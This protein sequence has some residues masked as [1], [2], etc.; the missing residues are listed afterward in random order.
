[1]RRAFLLVRQ[2]CNGGAP[3]VDGMTVHEL[4]PYC[5][6][7]WARIREELLSGTY[8]P[9]PV[10]QVEIPKPGGK[11][12]RKLGIPR[13]LDRLIQQS[14]LQVLTPVFDPTSSESS[15][16]FRPGR[17][18]HRAVFQAREHVETCGPPHTEP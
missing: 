5:R 15:F 12:K 3:G 13:C 1:M 9:Q 2:A 10:L 4:M 7:H 18:A 11:G 8:V 14:L 6:Q 17:S 16:G